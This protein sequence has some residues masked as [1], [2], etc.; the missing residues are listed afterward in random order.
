MGGAKKKRPKFVAYAAL[1]FPLG[2]LSSESDCA[3]A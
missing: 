1:K 2:P 3:F